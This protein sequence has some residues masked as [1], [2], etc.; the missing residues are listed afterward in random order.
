MR[1]LDSRR[2]AT[3]VAALVTF[4]GSH[5]VPAESCLRGTDVSAKVVSDESAEITDGQELA[6]IRNILEAIGDRPGLG[7]EVGPQY[8]PAMH[9]IWGFAVISSST[10]RDALE[11]ATRYFALSY[12]FSE[13]GYTVD[14]DEVRVFLDDRGIPDDVR[15]FLL[16]R[17]MSAII[18]GW[19]EM[20]GM[21]APFTRIEIAGGYF[22]RVRPLLEPLDVRI[23]ESADRHAFA[24]HSGWLDL[25]LPASSPQAAKM[26]EQQCAELLQRRIRRVG[27]A[28]EVREV[29]M[30]PGGAARS[31]P[32]VATELHLS[33][34]TM[35]RRLAEE[36]TSYREIAAET[37]GLLAEQL[38]ATGLPVEQVACRLGYSGA[39][40]FTTAFKQ[41]RGVTPGA[42]ASVR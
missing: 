10:A 22:E 36:D 16:E 2:P 42:F 7:F 14:G 35:R 28:G 39:P 5:G 1:P 40:S 33:V 24:F 32:E 20:F 29:L 38:L 34:R 27:L 9:G 13:A 31:Q 41:W 23:V 21:P 11:V 37:L 12:S 18:A 30:R 15:G 17:D 25:P 4:A 6:V 3:S 8:R 26:L 19:T